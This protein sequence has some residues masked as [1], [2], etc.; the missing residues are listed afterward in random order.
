MTTVEH[1]QGAAG[2]GKP[3]VHYKWIALSNTTVGILM[4]TINTSIMLIALPDIF[5]GLRVNPLVPSNVSLLLWMILGF[6]V[7]TAVLVVSFGRLGD[8][9]GRVRMYN[10]GFVIFTVFSTLLAVDWLHGTGG[11]LWIILMRLG[12]GVGGAF[13]FANSSAILTDAFPE[14]ERGLALGINNVAAIS[15]SFLGLILGGLLGPIEWRLVFVVSIPFGLFGTVWSY[16][17]LRDTGVRTAA[18]IDWW[19]NLTFAVGLI[20][21]LVGITYGIIPYGGNTMGWTNPFVLSMLFGGIVVLAIFGYIETKVHDPMFRLPLFRIRAFT[22]GN[23]ASLLASLGRGGMMFMLIIWL[24]GIW[25]PRHGYAFTNTPLWAGIYMLP[26]TVGF[27]LAGPASGFLSD[28]FGARPFATGGMLIAAL[29]FGLL[30]LLPVNFS[31][32]WFAL[33][34]LMNGLGMGLFAAPNRAG[35]MNSLPPRQRGAGAGMVATFQNSAMVLSIGVFFTLIITGLSSSLPKS[36]LSGLL[37][38]G[39]PHTAAVAASKLPPTSTVFS[40]LLGYN[41]MKTILGSTLTHL[42]HGEATYL[43]SRSFFP[44]LITKPFGNGLDE[45]LLFGMAALLLAAVASWLRGGKYHYVEGAELSGVSGAATGGSP[46]QP[47]PETAFSPTP[48][49]PASVATGSAPGGNGNGN[50]NGLAHAMAPAAVSGHLGAL[51]NGN[52]RAAHGPVTNGSSPT[53]TE[54]RPERL[55]AQAP[56]DIEGSSPE[57]SAA[58]LSGVVRAGRG[59]PLAGADVTLTDTTGQVVARTVTGPDGTYRFEDVAEGGYTVTASG[60]PPVARS[61]DL[62]A[63]EDYSLDLDLGQLRG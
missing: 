35:I 12:Q 57:A 19:G 8:M 56:A 6:M 63:T 1:E 18:H 51:G 15:G 53:A 60:F 61:V 58:R 30:I 48:P 27:L 34:L 17:K 44:A 32:L 11:A 40:A 28:R 55:T 41:P 36:M 2:G 31:Y 5:K 39:V 29:S 16:L 10:L 3:A 62:G 33:V 22:G 46:V 45:A 47:A 9:F 13:L 38:H 7:V 43:T 49:A 59:D 4:A 20:A 24:Q 54:S 23:F 14:N 42:P 25:L 52:G 50:G 37:A 21:V 26:M